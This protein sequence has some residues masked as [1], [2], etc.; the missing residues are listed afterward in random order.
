M[1]NP[2]GFLPRHGNYRELKSFRKTEIIYDLT[3]RFCARFLGKGDRTVD[4]MVQAARSGKQNIIEGAKAARTSKVT[5]LK[6]MGVARASLEELLGDYEDALRTRNAVIWSKEAPEAKYVRRRGAR[7][8]V[9]YDDFREFAETR[10]LEIVANIAL[11]LIHQANY[12]LDQQIL[13]LERDFLK[14][15]GLRERMAAARR[16]SRGQS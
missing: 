15:G 11:C 10:P 7:E 3:Y 16:K 2:D 1:S 9:S 8:D 5:E 13:R 4:Q 14:E 12:L 6:L